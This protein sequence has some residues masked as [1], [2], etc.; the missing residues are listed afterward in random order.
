MPQ[1]EIHLTPPTLSRRCLMI[2]TAVGLIVAHARPAA[3][4][5]KPELTVTDAL[6]QRRSTRVFADLRR[7]NAAGEDSAKHL[8]AQ[9]D[10]A[11]VA[12]NVYVFAAA[13]GLATCLVGGVDRDWIGK[14]LSFAAHE[15]V[16]FVQPV[17][18]PTD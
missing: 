14:V 8:Y 10:A 9:I 5:P 4:E 3:A 15:F 13:R 16:A 7:L 17:G 2:R 11:I 1:R 18:W 12:Q 6:R